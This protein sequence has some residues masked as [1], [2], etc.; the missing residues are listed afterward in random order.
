MNGSQKEQRRAGGVTKKAKKDDF[1]PAV[2]VGYVAGDQKQHDAREKLRQSDIAQ[3]KRA[4]GDLIDLPANG[5]G[6]HFGGK[7]DEEA[8]HLEEQKARI[9][10]G[11]APGRLGVLC[12][13]HRE[14]STVPQKSSS[15]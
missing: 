4:L 3:I 15:S 10:K 2:A 9:L 14:L 13:G 8:R 12:C 1:R 7:N 11:G 6:L 5:Y